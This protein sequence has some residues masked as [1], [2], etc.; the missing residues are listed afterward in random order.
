[1]DPVKQIAFSFNYSAKGWRVFQAELEL[2][3]D[4]QAGMNN[5]TYLQLLCEIRWCSRTNSLYTST[6]VVTA[7]VTAVVTALQYV[8][9]DEDGKA[10]RYSLSI[11]NV[12]FIITPV[13][14]EHVLQSRFPLT[15]LMQSKQYNLCHRGSHYNFPAAAGEGPP[16][17]MECTL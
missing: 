12:D 11:K 9:E 15:T 2:D 6:A 13:T 4:A 17:S 8:D 14:V 5:R 3:E 7:L 1:M 16:R 10:R